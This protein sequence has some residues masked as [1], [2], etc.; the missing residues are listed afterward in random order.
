MTAES[1]EKA[2]GLTFE[3]RVL[4]QHGLSSLG[5]DIGR[6]DGI[7]GART[8]TGIATVQK[9]KGLSET[10]HLSAELS[11]SLQ[12]LG[13]EAQAKQQRDE[14]S[15]RA[16]AAARERERQ[17]AERR[18]DDEAFADTKRLHTPA[19]YRAYLERGGRHETEARRLLAEVT[20]LKWEAGQKFR[21]CPDCPEL[22]VVPAGSYEMGSPSYEGVGGG[23]L[24][25]QLSRSAIGR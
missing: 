16:E 3:Q 22:V 14:E 1:E 13:R 4:V 18:A 12:A 24:V 20:K 23:L 17:A 11:E 6:V 8:R 5:A 7:F 15:R 10:G 21:D 25:R 2:L 9:E 19:S